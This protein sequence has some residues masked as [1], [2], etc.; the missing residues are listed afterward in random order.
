[1]TGA[2]DAGTGLVALLRAVAGPFAFDALRE[3]WLGGALALVAAALWLRGVGAAPPAAAWPAWAELRA[4]GARRRDPTRWLAAALRGVALAALALALAGPVSLRRVPPPPG[5]GLDVV[6]VLDASGSMRALDTEAGGDWRTRLDLARDVV[7]RFALER[8]AEGDRVGLVV[9]GETAHTQSPLASDGRLLA[10]A[11]ARVE[12]GMAGEATALG[13]ALALGVKRALGPAL[14][15][16]AAQGR[17][18]PATSPGE[19]RVVVLLTDGRSN[20]GSVPPDVA[21]GLARS[22]GVRVHAVGVGGAGPVP[23]ATAPGAPRAGLRFERHDLDRG[24]LAALAAATGGR[25]FHARRARDL[26]AVYAEIDALERVPRRPPPR[27]R[28]SPRHAAWLSLA[29]GALALEL[30]VT[31]VLWRSIP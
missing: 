27:L 4:A 31:R 20:A 13:D 11:L 2:D 29:A 16:A 23:M 8:V 24:T 30:G 18:R 19:G 9:F 26:A 6:L 10:T 25:F 7:R 22:L 5:L 21:A 17:D 3:P 28:E 12:A 15:E 14:R 1:M